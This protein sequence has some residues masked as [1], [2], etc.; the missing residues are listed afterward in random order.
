[1]ASIPENFLIRDA[2]EKDM[3]PIAEIYA[4]H[5]LHG[6]ASFEQTPPDVTEISRRWRALLEKALPYTIAERDGEIL[7]YAYAGP[8]RSR[9]AYRFTVENSVYVRPKLERQGL[10]RGL[11]ANLI[12][13]CTALGLRQMVA[14]IGDSGHEGSIGLHKA[15][16]FRMVGTIEAAGFKHG[17]WVDSVLMQ[18]RLGDGSTTR[19]ES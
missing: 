10:G 4:Y 19:P 9:P 14:V 18:R 16:G 2:V 12:E 15:L 13:R 7:G 11:L 5:V 3:A 6:L 17:K 8:Y 1:M